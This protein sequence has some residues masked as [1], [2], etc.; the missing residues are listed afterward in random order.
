MSPGADLLIYVQH[1]LGIGHLIRAARLARAMTRQGLE[2]VFVSGGAPVGGLDIGPA[3]F[4]QLTPIKAGDARFSF[5]ADARG[6]P[7]SD[8]FKAERRDQLLA[9]LR[10]TQPK[11]ILI[12]MFPFG[13]RALRFELLPLLEAARGRKHSPKIVCSLRDVLNQ[14]LPKAKGDWIIETANR[15]FDLVM[16]HGDPAF[17]PLAR[18]FPRIGELAC[19]LLYT[20]YV[21]PDPLAERAPGSPAG[22]ADR[23]EV[24]VSAGGGAVGLPLLRCALAAQPLSRFAELKWRV[25]VGPSLS[26]L[27]LQSLAASAPDGVIVERPR[28]DF[29]VLLGAAR[30]SVSQAGYNTLTEVL[31]AQ[32]PAVVVPFAEDAETEQTQRAAAL[33]ERGLVTLVPADKLNPGILADAVDRAVAAVSPGRAPA[34][35]LDLAGAERSAE[36]MAQLIARSDR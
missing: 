27:D 15:W 32:V 35:A 33:A 19:P 34:P 20:G 3:R 23:V 26:A 8:P 13:R 30:A 4:A 5:L 28:H 31:Q 25:L 2:V 12:E 6:A 14:Q 24:L 16:V 21:A 36:I 10:G 29:Q 9:L 1:L 22:V 11:A 7:I 17:L 18:S